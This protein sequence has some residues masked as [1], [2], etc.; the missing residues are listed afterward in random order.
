MNICILFISQQEGGKDAG[1]HGRD[2][3]GNFFSIL[4]SPVYNEETTGLAFS[5]NHKRMYVAYQA[6]GIL[7]EVWRKDGLPFSAKSLN[8]KYHNTQSGT[9]RN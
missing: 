7:L 6:N 4:E 1:I 5:P 9:V 2:S 8:I 3:E